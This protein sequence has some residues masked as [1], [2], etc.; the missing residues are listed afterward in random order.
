MTRYPRRMGQSTRGKTALNRLR[1]VD[2]YLILAL[3]ECLYGT[4]LVVDLGYGA[5]PWTTLEMAARLGR[6]NPAVRCL[7]IEID[8][9]RVSAAQPY[10]TSNVQFQ[11]GGFNI[12]DFTGVGA[13]SVIRAYNVLRQYQEAEVGAALNTMAR[14]LQT[15]GVLIEGTSNPTGG[16]AVFDVYR[17]NKG[18]LQHEAL[19]FATNLNARIADIPSDFQTI[20]PKRLIH[21][22]R[23]E[24]LDNFFAAWRRAYQIARA[25]CIE[26]SPIHV[27]CTAADWLHLEG[28]YPIDMRRRLLRRGFLPLHTPLLPPPL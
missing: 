20:L 25:L 2:N 12:S 27:W 9:A 4:P 6:V 7:G 3:A 26:R 28:G 1:R 13:V 16:I 21:H 24:S 15:G 22:M 18:S 10:A 5:Y 14:A 8:P 23:E 19:V 11:L 17:Q